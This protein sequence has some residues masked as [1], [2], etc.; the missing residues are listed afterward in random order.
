M[1]DVV[2][3][4]VAPIATRWVRLALINGHLLDR[5]ARLLRAI[6]RHRPNSKPVTRS[7]LITRDAL[8]ST[9]SGSLVKRTSHLMARPKF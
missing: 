6:R 5:M 2:L 8:V 3:A 4:S 1:F 7:P 9:F